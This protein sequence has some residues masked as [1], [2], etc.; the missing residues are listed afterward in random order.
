[1]K[2]TTEISFIFHNFFL[3]HFIFVSQFLINLINKSFFFVKITNNLHQISIHFFI[4]TTL[5]L[6]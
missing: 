5:V 6:F 2:I 1:M 4:R 3:L